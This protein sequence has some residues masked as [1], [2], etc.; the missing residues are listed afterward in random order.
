MT[1]K[2]E[3]RI[4]Y[5]DTDAAGIVYYANYLKF[6]ERART[7][8]LRSLGFNQSN[9]MEQNGFGFVVKHVEA[10]FIAPAKL[11]D[12]IEIETILKS[13]NKAS[14]D[15]IQL[16]KKEDKDL[17]SIRVTLACLNKQGKATRVI[18]ELFDKI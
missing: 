5:E 2:M 15:M 10:D 6:A 11:D 7:E 3:Y 16:I 9:L 4:Y 17:V 13:L 8:W 18:P 14:I 12:V 1:H